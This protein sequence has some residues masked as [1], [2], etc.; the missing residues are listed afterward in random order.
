M[1]ALRSVLALLA[2]LVAGWLTVPCAVLAL[3]ALDGFGQDASVLAAAGWGLLGLACPA[4][5]LL[6]THW[7]STRLFGAGLA[8][9]VVGVASAVVVSGVF[10]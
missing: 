5:G 8:A 9:Y 4:I 2:P 10:A 6:L 3:F 7:L 1:A